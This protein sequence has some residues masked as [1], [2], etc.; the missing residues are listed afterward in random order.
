MICCDLYDLFYLFIYL[1]MFVLL[2]R[3]EKLTEG[4]WEETALCAILRSVSRK[5]K[6][7][8]LEIHIL[9][10]FFFVILFPFLVISVST[11]YSF[12]ETITNN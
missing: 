6:K 8:I 4:F 5:K 1:Y 2:R 10:T 9:L 7:K 12:I 11:S 3:D